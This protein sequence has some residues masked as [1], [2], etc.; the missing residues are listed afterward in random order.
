M[1]ADKT[2]AEKQE[3][4]YRA[5]ERVLDLEVALRCVPGLTA[6]DREQLAQDAELLARCDL[7]DAMFK[8]DLVH[9]LRDLRGSESEGI[10]LQAIKEL[11][12]MFYP[13]RFSQP[14][15]VEVTKPIEHVIRHEIVDPKPSPEALEAAAS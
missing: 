13:K 6:E 4:A 3:L 11:G 10:K 12:K 9:G 5:Y 8:E 2:Y 15:Q 7:C 14:M 1:S